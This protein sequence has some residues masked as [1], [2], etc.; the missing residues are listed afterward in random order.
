M[1]PTLDDLLEVLSGIKAHLVQAEKEVE[2]L[3]AQ[4]ERLREAL[5]KVTMYCEDG[6]PCTGT[7]RCYEHEVARKGLEEN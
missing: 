6:N 7:C 5:K 2:A 4:K 3:K 1:E